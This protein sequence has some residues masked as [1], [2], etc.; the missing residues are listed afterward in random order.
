M[1]PVLFIALHLH[2]IF[3][4]CKMAEVNIPALIGIIVSYILFLGIGVYAAKKRGK[5]V[6]EMMLAGRSLGLF[7][8]ICTMTG[9]L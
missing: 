4:F 5:G 6:E 7:L 9:K 1:R 2:G 3:V 8:G